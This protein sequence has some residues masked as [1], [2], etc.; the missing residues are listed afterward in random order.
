MFFFSGNKNYFFLYLVYAE[1]IQMFCSSRALLAK[2][3]TIFYI[4]SKRNALFAHAH[5]PSVCVI[6]YTCKSIAILCLTI[7]EY[8]EWFLLKI[9]RF[10]DWMFE[11]HNLINNYWSKRHRK[12]G[13]S[14]GQQL[15][16]FTLKNRSVT[17]FYGILTELTTYYS[18]T[19]QKKIYLV[20]M[21]AVEVYW[22]VEIKR[23]LFI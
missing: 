18:R 2:Q 12:R 23:W 20:Q 22:L 11:V 14:R 16:H 17:K 4:L 7:Y 15:F 8:I 5:I 9:S 13:L 10:T 19:M 1:I 6:K 3:L 21:M